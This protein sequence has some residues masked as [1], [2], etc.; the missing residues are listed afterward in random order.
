MIKKLKAKIGYVK[1]VGL[2]LFLMNYFIK[3]IVGIDRGCPFNKN[4]TSR[5][6]SGENVIIEDNSLSVLKSFSVSGGCYIQAS[7]GIEIG[8]GTIWSF[9]VSLVSLDHDIKNFN[10]KVDKGPIKIGRNCWLGAGAVVLPGVCL[11]DNTIVGAN[12]VVT[13]SFEEGNVVI[14]GV[15][16]KV[17]RRL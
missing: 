12:A 4:Y 14:A 15:P 3:D 17:L 2:P 6:I 5:V 7:E 9:N 13:K 1:S 11:G 10:K 16:A 8:K